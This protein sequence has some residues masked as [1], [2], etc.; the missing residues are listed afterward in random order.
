MKCLR[1]SNHKHLPQINP[2]DAQENGTCATLFP[3]FEAK[4]DDMLTVT[5]EQHILEALPLAIKHI[6]LTSDKSCLF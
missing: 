6:E 1:D 5:I 3:L 4:L 2:V